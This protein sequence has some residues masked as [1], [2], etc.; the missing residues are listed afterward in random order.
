HISEFHDTRQ[1]TQQRLSVLILP[2]DSTNYD[3]LILI[4]RLHGHGE[5]GLAEFRSLEDAHKTNHF[6][7]LACIANSGVVQIVDDFHIPLSLISKMCDFLGPTCKKEV[8]V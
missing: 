5:V 3:S 6:V 1:I 4:Q 2:V 7:W 8:Q